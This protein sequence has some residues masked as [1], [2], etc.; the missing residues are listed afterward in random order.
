MWQKVKRLL[1]YYR[2]GLIV[3][4]K[5]TIAYPTS[6]WFGAI[7]IPLWVV[8]QILFIET[9]YGQTSNFLGY[10]KFENYV[11]FG[12][13]KIVQSFAMIFF[14]VKLENLTE[15]IRGT[16]D[17]SLDAMLLKPI[18]PQIYATTG[19][20]WFGSISSLL[21][22]AALVAYGFI[23]EPHT[24]TIWQ[25][26]AYSTA[27]LLGVFLLYLLY[28]FIQTWLFWFEY[29]QVGQDL[30]FAFQNLGQ[31]PRSLFVGWGSVVLNVAVPITLMGAIPVEFLYGKIPPLQLLIYVVSII[32]L[33]VLT[34]MFWQYSIKK[35]SS[36]SS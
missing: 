26:F 27:V 14:M 22:G 5:A 25:V 31:Y 10:T 20:Y 13:F 16:G 19:G 9:I 6:F 18:D 1:S 32:I 8:I 7:T 21:S 4:I 11:L 34:R 17:Q 28:L 29:L 35:Y 23:H 30:W 3:D 36:F 33:F 15:Q 24:V 2:L 12:T